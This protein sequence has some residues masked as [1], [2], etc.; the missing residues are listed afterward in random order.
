VEKSAPVDAEK[1]V[2]SKLKRGELRS[3]RSP[4]RRH[5]SSISPFLHIPRVWS[6]VY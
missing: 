4:G 2:L 3:D 6:C 1:S 5:A